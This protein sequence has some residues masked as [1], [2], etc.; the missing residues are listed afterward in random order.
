MK[1]RT[2]FD[3]TA[4]DCDRKAVARQ[5]C[6]MHYLRWWIHG[7]TEI[8]NPVYTG[9]SDE[10]RF[11]KRVNKTDTCWLWTGGQ[12]GKG[13]GVFRLNGGGKLAHRVAYQFVKGEIPEGLEIDHLCKV[14]HCV[15]PSHLEAVTRLENMLR[16]DNHIA[17]L[18]KR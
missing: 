7:T 8:P 5:L 13:Y 18:I 6:K 2:N 10:D 14:R 1:P 12:I 3:C 16:S 17:K 11:W 15:N 4:N 9:Y